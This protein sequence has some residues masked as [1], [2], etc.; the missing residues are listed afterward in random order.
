MTKE[1]NLIL[2]TICNQFKEQDLSLLSDEELLSLINLRLGV[3]TAILHDCEV[4]LN[5]T[6]MLE[7]SNDIILNLIR[8]IDE[9]IKKNSNNNINNSVINYSF[10]NTKEKYIGNLIII[11]EKLTELY[12]K[13]KLILEENFNNNLTIMLSKIFLA[14]IIDIKNF[15]EWIIKYNAESENKYKIT[16]I[17]NF[18]PLSNILLFMHKN[19][20][21]EDQIDIIKKMLIIIEL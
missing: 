8:G 5:N 10:I 4:V 9:K 2:E 20:F 17:F 14:L 12:F 18:K 1:I 11:L 13:K 21:N 6:K 16:K 7:L 15:N 3:I 19:N